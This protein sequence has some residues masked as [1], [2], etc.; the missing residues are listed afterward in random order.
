MIT[1]KESIYSAIK[2]LIPSFYFQQ[3]P[4]SEVNTVVDI[5]AEAITRSGN[6]IASLATLYDIDTID[7][8]YLPYIAYAIG[9]VYDFRFEDTN[10]FLSN[11]RILRN[12]LKQAVAW[13]RLKGTVLAVKQYLLSLGIR[14]SINEL[15]YVGSDY[16]DLIPS[17]QRTRTIKNELFRVDIT[18]NSIQYLYQNAGIDPS[19]INSDVIEFITG[20]FVHTNIVNNSIRAYIHQG[21]VLKTIIEQDANGNFNYGYDSF[22]VLKNDIAVNLGTSQIITSEK[23]NYTIT[24]A[25]N[26]LQFIIDDTYTETIILPQSSMT[27]ATVLAMSINSQSVHLFARA[28][29]N[30]LIITNDT[31][32]MYGTI[33]VV[34]VPNNA[35]ATMGISIGV[36]RATTNTR[37]DTV[38]EFF[39]IEL[40]EPYDFGTTAGTVTID[41]DYIEY[42]QP[43]SITDYE[44]DTGAKSNWFDITMTANNDAF[45][46]TSDVVDKLMEY[47][48]KEI[49]PFH[50]L[51]RKVNYET[52]LQDTAPIP[53]DVTQ[54][55][56]FGDLRDYYQQCCLRHD[57]CIRFLYDGA[58]PSRVNTG[59]TRSNGCL[60]KGML[61]TY[62]GF[63][64]NR[65][66]TTTFTRD[67]SEYD[68][69]ALNANLD[70]ERT[71]AFRDGAR[72]RGN[73]LYHYDY[74]EFPK[75]VGL[76]YE[77]YTIEQNV[78]DALLISVRGYAPYAI[79]LPSGVWTAE[80][81]AS[82]I[83]N[84]SISSIVIPNTLHQ[85]GMVESIMVFVIDDSTNR[86]YIYPNETMIDANG[87]VELAFD[88]NQ[89]G[90]ALLAQ[91]G[92]YTESFTSQTQVVIAGATHGLGATDALH[93]FVYSDDIQRKRI[94][95][96]NYNV[97][98]NGTVTIDFDTVQSGI[99][100]IRNASNYKHTFTATD[101]I[102]IPYS[103]HT[104]SADDEMVIQVYDSTGD[105]VI[106]REIAITS[107][108]TITVTLDEVM[109]GYVVIANAD[110][111]LEFDTSLLQGIKA[112]G[113]GG[114]V[115]I[116]G[117]TGF[118]FSGKEISCLALNPVLHD[119]YDTLGFAEDEY[120]GTVCPETYSHA[121]TTLQTSNITTDQLL[122]K[123][124][125]DSPSRKEVIPDNIEVSATGVIT[126]LFDT[127]QVGLLLLANNYT[128]EHA[129]SV[130][131][132]YLV[133]IPSATHGLGT[134]I[135]F[136]VVVYT[137]ESPRKQIFPSDITI[138]ASTG[139][140]VVA[141]DSDQDGSIVIRK[142]FNHYIKYVNITT[143]GQ[144]V[145]IPFSEHLLGATAEL[146]VYV[147]NDN[148]PREVVIPR[149]VEINNSGDIVVT[150]DGID[151]VW[152]VVH[153]N[154][155][156]SYVFDTAVNS[157][158]VPNVTGQ[159]YLGVNR[160]ERDELLL[161][162]N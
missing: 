135:N 61:I 147:Y 14:S 45:V 139:N 92:V 39:V 58:V 15:W 20:S 94:K 87:T 110:Y 152:I 54:F 84:A 160:T 95:P 113:I 65:P 119:V 125:D 133:S 144:Q 161:T 141:F 72:Y 17:Q 13:M 157:V 93:L 34:D 55:H 124:Y 116:V 35:Y 50:A 143:T 7:V 155:E 154:W 130:T 138:D 127:P 52:L 115:R 33:E 91:T 137:N 68:N 145:V 70:S 42:G 36:Y 40:L 102:T 109:D 12:Q 9:Y 73:K 90:K 43:D 146:G 41:Y 105:M 76:T 31:N 118:D 83:N 104:V 38:S 80:Q 26:I 153:A 140:I 117:T 151:D 53:D 162:I 103:T 51:L 22:S 37:F 112:Y 86:R 49:K 66:S 136:G 158:I 32:S 6:D 121:P 88:S 29:N 123:I 129:F 71:Y 159:I 81:I 48:K 98:S 21:G 18:N 19:R 77:N 101:S 111:A 120:C 126:L 16:S 44:Y 64:Q 156:F 5:F 149:E 134:G 1:I 142:P 100:L 57:N 79:T 60:P 148:S 62:N 30:R 89:S 114:F 69:W 24:F 122:F 23:A 74:C 107:A 132:P 85:L 8:N 97:A 28:D 108:G 2:R 3:I 10:A 67:L 128:Y 59:L 27:S 75:A 99:I 96:T 131:S 78:N 82:F 4:E 46:L 150:L 25:N 106:P 56:V 11:E 47:V 63:I